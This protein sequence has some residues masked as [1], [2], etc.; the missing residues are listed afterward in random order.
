M[1]EVLAL[2][3]QH[4]WLTGI[5]VIWGLSAIGSWRRRAHKRKVELILA[6]QGIVPPPPEKKAEDDDDDEFWGPGGF[7]GDEG[8]EDKPA[9]P[10]ISISVKRG[11]R[12]LPAA[13]IPSPPSVRPSVPG[14]CRHEKIVPVITRD[15]ELVKWLC[16]NYA[17]CDAEFPRDTA[18]Y[19]P[20]GEA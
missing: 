7:W 13:A 20:E 2:L 19:D 9:A 18:V 4:P 15:G 6:R 1:H 14:P 16:A 17:R 3:G 8:D 11:H 5:G 12:P 10:V